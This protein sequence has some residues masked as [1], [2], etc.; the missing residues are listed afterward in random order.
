MPA[1]S[2]RGAS[3]RAGGPGKGFDVRSALLPAVQDALRDPKLRAELMEHG[4]KVAGN[5]QEWR[6]ER[7]GRE[8]SA[9]ALSAVR[10]QLGD[11]VGQG[12][13]ER[14]VD[15]LRAAVATLGERRPELAAGLAPVSR[16]IEEVATSLHVAGSLPLAKRKRAHVTIDRALDDLERSLFESSLPGAAG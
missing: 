9:G 13:L 15:N 10:R 7:Q 3:K 1:K 12:K 5:V 16:S 14:R 2:P 11:R 6:R 4:R 8:A